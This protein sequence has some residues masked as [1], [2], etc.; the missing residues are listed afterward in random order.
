MI[1]D[2]TIYNDE[3]AK[4][5]DAV[6]EFDY[7]TQQEDYNKH[8]IAWRRKKSNP[9]AYNFVINKNESFF[10]DGQGFVNKTAAEAESKT[11]IRIIW[12]IGIAMLSAFCVDNIFDKGLVMFL[13]ALGV[14]IH[15]ALFNSA[16]AIYGGRTEL[17]VILI[18]LTAAEFAVPTAIIH[19][20]FKMPWQVRFPCTLHDPGELTGT[21]AAAMILCVVSGFP[22]AYS[23]ESR[24]IYNFFKTYKADISGLGQKEFIIYTIFDVVIVSIISEALFRGE[25][26]AALRQFGDVF[27]VI[28]TSVLSGLLTQNF[29]VMISVMLMSVVSAVGTLRSG[30]ILSAISAKIVYKV[31]ML[32]LTII[33]SSGLEN[34]HTIRFV[35]LLSVLLIGILTLTI[36]FINKERRS[37]KIFASY[38]AKISLKGKLLAA[39][40][41][42]PMAVS[43]EVFMFAALLKIIL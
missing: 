3:D 22:A 7:S 1:K 21:V 29:K 23:K 15:N 35:Y 18:I 34:M 8:F 27:A 17:V 10:I 31:Y 4:V 33:E 19:A 13:E 37:R 25:M 11:L 20:K 42:L 39:I 14:N 9:Y 6:E 5:F 26:F 43:V 28:V 41:C 16:S 2:Q 24:D 30:T 36:V 38:N 32:V 12:V 40:R